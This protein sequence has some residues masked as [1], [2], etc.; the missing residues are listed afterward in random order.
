MT[1]LDVTNLIMKRIGERWTYRLLSALSDGELRFAELLRALAP[2][3][4]KVLSETLFRLESDGFVRRRI[5]DARPP[6]VKYQLTQLGRD[7][8]GLM[9]SIARWA[10][11]HGD[12]VL[13]LANQASRELT[14]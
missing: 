4:A 10:S 6:Q 7:M 1:T 9:N 11:A 3:K 5:V 12:L 14:P 13:S 2:V 8:V